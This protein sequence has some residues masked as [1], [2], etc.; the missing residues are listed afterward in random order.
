MLPER[1]IKA[2]EESRYL[3]R[4]YLARNYRANAVIPRFLQPAY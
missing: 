4:N 1:H 3:A 2:F